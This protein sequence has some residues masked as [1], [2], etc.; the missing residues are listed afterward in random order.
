M[1]RLCI[2]MLGLMAGVVLAADPPAPPK[3]AP[4]RV[5]AVT[6]YPNSALVTREVEV[7]GGVGS[8]EL[9]VTPLPPQTVNSSLYSEADPGIR[10]LTT[11]FR[12]RPIKEDT[13]EE[14][15][16]LEAQLR[17]LQDAAQKL[18]S[19]MRV[20]DQNL[21][22]LMKLEGFTGTTLQHLT[23]K[24]QLNS[25]A[26]IAL[27]KYIMES[28]TEKSEALVANRLQQQQNQEQMQYVQRKLQEMA[29]G[30]NKTE[31]DAII[32]VEKKDAAPGKIRLNYLVDSASWRPQYKLRAGNG[33]ANGNGKAKDSI[34]VE[35]QA[36]VVQQT[37]EDWTGVDLTLST[38]Q[39]MLN[40]AP[41]ELGML[42]VT[43]VP[44]NTP[45]LVGGPGGMGFGGFSGGAAPGMN[46]P[47]SGT[48][49]PPVG[50]ALGANAPAPAAARMPQGAN[51]PLSQL[52]VTQPA[53]AADYFAQ[54]AQS[55]RS[56]AELQYKGK[57]EKGGQAT[58]NT[59]AALE[60]A[61]EILA[62]KEEDIKA[63]RKPTSPGEGPSVTYH[64]ASRLAIPSRH[65][66]Q[67]IEVAR[68]ELAP[69]YFYK[70]VPVLTPHVYRLA[71]LTNTSAYVL[72]PG[73]ATMYLGSDFVGRANLPLVA[74]GEQF[75]AGFGVDPQLQV[76]RQLVDKSRTMQGDNQI[77]KFEYRILVSSYKAEAVPVQL[78]DRLPHTDTEAVGV[79]LVK[80]T[81]E[82]SQD[83]V[84]LREGRP[85]N[86]LRW[87]L[88]VPPATT[89][90]KALAINYEF[91]LEMGR[92]MQLGNFTA[93]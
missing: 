25:E 29:A 71:N 24:G 4:N 80:T 59:A 75:T 64:L 28:R 31:R 66:E 18:Q 33:K 81:P 39:P 10:V 87:D 46:P 9:V 51:K 30:S 13:R 5:L 88:R 83:P 77:L 63:G 72:L 65:D 15:R 78:W 82:V 84:Y 2:P 38:A 61:K 22:M 12:Q 57:D 92:Q 40:A 47:A 41:P 35:Y 50:A 45:G 34:Q 7:P 56:K 19:D 68:L 20:L 21:Q 48:L 23:D 93:K 26:T 76:Q 73:E 27:A 79:S 62:L 58:L 74:I 32:V 14:V 55:L 16:K 17:Q 52:A 85:H 90:E 89:G 42:A 49:A 37:G 60:Q 11:R 36:A 86:L 91:R 69:D 1:L 43:V 70:A 54:Q 3:A 6:V 53:N 67:V 44:R 8:F